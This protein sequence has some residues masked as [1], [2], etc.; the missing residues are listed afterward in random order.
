MALLTACISKEIPTTQTYIDTEM[1]SEPYQVTE[2][3]D[4]NTPNVTPVYT[5]SDTEVW[6]SYPGIPVQML[7]NKADDNTIKWAIVGIR[8]DSIKQNQFSINE[9][10]KW[11]ISP[12]K[13]QTQKNQ[14]ISIKFNKDAVSMCIQ[15]Q[16]RADVAKQKGF[17]PLSDDN[18]R[19]AWTIVQRIHYYDLIT[20]THGLKDMLDDQ[21][22]T[23]YIDTSTRECTYDQKD[24]I[25]ANPIEIP[26]DIMFKYEDWALLSISSPAT[27]SYIWD[28]ITTGTHEVTKY[29]DVPH[30]VQK[31]R[32]VM[33]TKSVPFW[34]TFQTK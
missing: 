13:Q 17:Q 21:Y 16:G 18:I 2:Q 27:I 20:T 6:R 14:R 29:R 15:I 3:Y 7:F 26:L 19:S 34:E 12:I 33:V 25:L 31:Q 8:V 11:G 22:S 30:Q 24:S 5:V 28:S 10:T 32:T 1:S 4:I 9:Q 23:G